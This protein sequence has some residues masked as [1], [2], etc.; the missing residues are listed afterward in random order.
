MSSNTRSTPAVL[1]AVV[2]CSLS[3]SSFFRIPRS[4]S[5]ISISILSVETWSFLGIR[6]SLRLGLLVRPEAR[7]IASHAGAPVGHAYDPQRPEHAPG[8]P[9]MC[10]TISPRQAHRVALPPWPRPDQLVPRQDV[11]AL[12]RHRC[13]HGP[14]P[15]R[16]D[17][18]RSRRRLAP[19]ASARAHDDLALCKLRNRLRRRIEKP[20]K[21]A[22]RDLGHAVCGRNLLK[23]LERVMGIEPTTRSLGSYC[24][25]T[26]LHPPIAIMRSP[27]R[28]TWEG[29]KA[30]G[31]HARVKA[32]GLA[33]Q[34]PPPANA[35]EP[36]R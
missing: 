32:L 34:T 11:P 16:E 24:S 18:G 12:A 1:V 19:I 9:G 20:S 28:M 33:V 15:L 14:P 7:G 3:R 17:A 10:S 6:P 25:T 23:I 13:R 36:G 2:P 5:Y 30:T 35:R 27:T 31:P 21:P 8:S 29:R 26:E 22:C 4:R